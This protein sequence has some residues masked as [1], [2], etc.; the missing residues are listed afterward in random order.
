MSNVSSLV[1]SVQALWLLLRRRRRCLAWIFALNG[2]IWGL[3]ALYIAVFTPQPAFVALSQTSL[4]QDRTYAIYVANWGFHSSIIVEQPRGWQLGPPHAPR[5]AFVEY[6]WGDRRIF[7]QD[8]WS[9]PTVLA[10]AFLPTDSIVYLR[11][12]P[13]PPTRQDQVRQ[14]YH[15]QV[16]AQQLQALVIS[17]E[18]SFQR[19]AEGH[20]LAPYVYASR[21]KGRFYPGREFYIFW[22]NCN[23]WTI[24]HL[25]RLGIAEKGGPILLAEQVGPSLEGFQLQVSSSP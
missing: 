5:S 10:A 3:P 19:T 7:M 13:A 22:A 25:E 24:H 20:R 1:S 15:R 9:I 17:L 18:Q 4:A 16:T 23:G 2:S 21:F 12:R 14:L 8:D 11:D 6:G